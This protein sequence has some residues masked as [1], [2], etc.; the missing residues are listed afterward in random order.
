MK[1]MFKIEIISRNDENWVEYIIPTDTIKSADAFTAKCL[2]AFKASGFDS[3]E[4]LFYA[5]SPANVT[6][7]RRLR[8]VYLAKQAF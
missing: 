7:W 2:E 3:A 4:I 5:E 8:K 6:G 1:K